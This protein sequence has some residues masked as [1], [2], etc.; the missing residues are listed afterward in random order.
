MNKKIYTG[1]L[2][3]SL[4]FLLFGGEV[5]T[6]ALSQSPSGYIRLVRSMAFDETGVSNPVGIAFSIQADNF[7]VVGMQGQNLPASLAITQMDRFAGQSDTDLITASAVE[8]INLAFDN[9]AGRL[10]IYQNATNTL[11]EVKQD[12]E[13]NLLPPSL[14]T[15]EVQQFGVQS[16]QGMSVDS[17]SG[18]L[19]ILDTV[20]PQIV[21]VSPGADGTFS[22]AAVSSVDLGS[23]GG[24]NL[25]GVAVDPSTGNFFVVSPDELKLY[26][27]HATGVVAAVRD[28][29]GFGIVNPQG[30][31]FAPSGD[32][33][34][35][36]TT[37]S[38]YLADSGALTAGDSTST[39]PSQMIDG[40][41]DIH[42]A[43]QIVE[44]S[45]IEIPAAGT[46]AFPSALVA[47]RDLSLLSPPIPDPTGLTYVSTS[48]TLVVSDS[49]VEETVNGIT[50]FQGAN[51][52]ELTLDASVVV[53]G[54]ISYIPP[55]I[56]AFS[57]EPNGVAFNPSNGHYYF[58]DD[59][60]NFV[61]DLAPGPD[62][63][64]WTADD[65]LDG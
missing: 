6:P 27:I 63:Q 9:K 50:Q 24:S 5:N 61:F 34:D 64:M 33:T 42:T 35:D 26:E 23:V 2:I 57:N 54:N 62:G 37:M 7:H 51:V 25:R 45:M 13:G 46:A 11:V 8:P 44:L 1:V 4:I 10:L 55:T 60:A 22:G 29:S 15:H 30:L 14:T 16:P 40:T 12:S 28:L 41:T 36:P 49:E 65:V 52:W 56:L 20:G 19:F 32:Q 58:T 48:N 31:V 38:L 21:H 43:G 18:D 47:T 39:T 3:L 53:T 59:N 17:Q